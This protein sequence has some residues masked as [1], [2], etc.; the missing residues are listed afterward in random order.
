MR[1]TKDRLLEL[2]IFIGYSVEFP[3]QLSR[4]IGGSMDW[5]RHVMYRAIREGYVSLYRRKD[6][7]YVI[8]SLS[9]TQ[10]G[11][12]YVAER[13]P[14]ALAMI[15][16]RISSS[17]KIYPSKVDKILRLHA[18]AYSL[19][20][21]N[22]AGAII[23]PARKPSLLRPL[24]LPTEIPVD[25]ATAYYYSPQEIRAAFEEAD[26]R[27]VA[28]GSRLIGII[29][30]GHRCYCMYY[31]GRTRMFWMRLT[32]ENT[33]AAI[34]THLNV[35]GF[36]VRTLCQIVIGNRTNVAVKLCRS[37][38]PFGDRY[39]VV[40]HFFDSVHFITNNAEG[41]ELLRLIINPDQAMELNRLILS[42][43]QPPR[44]TT[45]EYDAVDTE[46]NRPVLINYAC[47]LIPLSIARSTPTGFDGGLIMLCFDYQVQTIQSIVGPSVEVRP[48]QIEGKYEKA[49][50]QDRRKP[51]A[52][53]P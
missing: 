20:A 52:A 26:D 36:K 45:R 27:T 6:K 15:Y 7:R 35:R 10:K 32:E 29:V 22:A 53:D 1:E 47:D 28:K 11:F 18:I 5:N 25:P 50:N 17:Q 34:L 14:D 21:A 19:V 4:R 41:D 38:N 33:A 24:G 37:P 48:I 12:D 39:F 40:S 51:G 30:R 43:Y 23:Q 16:S 49:K 3:V 2:L 9:L 44:T 13:D 42:P 31:A 8:R 46:S